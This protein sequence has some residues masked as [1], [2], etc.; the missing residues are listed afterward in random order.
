[1]THGDL[2][3]DN[4]F[5]EKDHAWAIDFE[6]SEV[7]H[8]LRDF[9]ELEEDIITR[10]ITLPENDLSLF[11]QVVLVLTTPIAPT[12]P[13]VAPPYFE[14]D[15]EILKALN[16][17]HGLRS[18]AHRMT[19]FDDMHEYYWG[20]L[21]DACFSL[22]LAEPRSPKWYRGMLLSSLLCTRL[23]EWGRAWPTHDWPAI[24]KAPLDE[25]HTKKSHNIKSINIGNISI[26][27]G[28]SVGDIV[29]ASEIQRSFNKAESAII[30]NELKVA[31]KQL[32]ESVNA[33][34]K[35]LPAAQAAEAAEDLARLVD[36]ATKPLPNRK[37]YS[38]SI[39]G[40]IKAAENVEKVGV[41][42][43]NL[44]QKVLSLLTGGLAS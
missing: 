12:T 34:N 44:S 13:I 29:L 6:R 39:E 7:G 4:L 3:G 8:V 19:H 2:H 23:K 30:Q 25:T 21:L 27:N 17:I 37:W 16:V 40:L 35:Q 11:Y 15:E 32:A 24:A 10:L 43:I 41:P 1:V 31:L 33:M 28:A 36:E 42:V 22:M 14:K 9:V 38:V 5:I 18:I 20:L 26:G